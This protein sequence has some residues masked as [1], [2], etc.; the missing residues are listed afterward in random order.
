M[1]EVDP[2]EVGAQIAAGQRPKRRSGEGHGF[3]AAAKPPHE[4]SLPVR[5]GLAVH[6]VDAVGPEC[7]RQLEALGGPIVPAHVVAVD[8]DPMEAGQAHQCVERRGIGEPARHRQDQ[9]VAGREVAA[10]AAQ[11]RK[12]VP[13]A[14]PGIALL[15]EVA[16][17]VAT[18]A[19]DGKLEEGPA[20]A[21]LGEPVVDG[22]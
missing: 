15:A 11:V 17:E 14:R 12:P 6:P 4:L 2:G 7:A 8:D 18:P 21:V 3:P 20:R 10:P 19:A 9:V 22:R 5:A 1:G 16:H 13:N